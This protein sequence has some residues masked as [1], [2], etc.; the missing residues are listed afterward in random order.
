MHFGMGK[1]QQDSTRGKFRNKC[2]PS[3]LY[4]N[5][6]SRYPGA[7]MNRINVA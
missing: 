3:D 2:Y 6:K 1:L 4:E 7:S 5:D